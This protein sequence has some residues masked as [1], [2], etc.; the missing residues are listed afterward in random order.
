MDAAMTAVGI[1]QVDTYVLRCQNTI[2][3]YIV[4][5]PILDL[6]MAAEQRPVERVS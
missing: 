3:Q 5:H 1:E 4:T 6:C 2:P